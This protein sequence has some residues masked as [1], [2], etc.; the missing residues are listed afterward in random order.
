M[1]CLPYGQSLHG[2]M[3]GKNYMSPRATM[4]QK[5]NSSKL[6]DTK[7]TKRA[8]GSLSIKLYYFVW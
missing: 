7:K 6:K 3:A 1:Y 5:Y 2:F 4:E 8:P